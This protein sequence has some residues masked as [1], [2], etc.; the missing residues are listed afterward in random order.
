MSL[1]GVYGGG[2]VFDRFPAGVESLQLVACFRL[3]RPEEHAKIRLIFP[4]MPTWEVDTTI[5]SNNPGATATHIIGLSPVVFPSPGRL[6]VEYAFEKGS[7]S[8]EM[9]VLL[10][11]DE[12]RKAWPAA[13]GKL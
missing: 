1:L 3:Y 8:R 10:R 9:D 5:A 13:P 4:G 11:A 2:I 7:V 12:E 6:Q